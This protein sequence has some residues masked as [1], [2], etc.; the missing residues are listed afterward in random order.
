MPPLLWLSSYFLLM[1]GAKGCYEKGNQQLKK[2]FWNSNSYRVNKRG[3]Y[4]KWY[5]YKE[6][7]TKAFLLVRESKVES[8][9]KIKWNWK[10]FTCQYFETHRSMQLFSPIFSSE[11]LYLLENKKPE[12]IKCSN[13]APVNIMSW[14]KE[15]VT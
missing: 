4:I 7:Y 13:K 15:T 8:L 10:S 5:T 9:L 14:M 3:E 11:S 12:Q 2:Y 6:W 1:G